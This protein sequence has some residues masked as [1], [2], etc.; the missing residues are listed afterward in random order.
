[1]AL[2][3]AGTTG[4]ATVDFSTGSSDCYACHAAGTFGF[5]QNS[6]PAP[7]WS[8]SYDDETISVP[9]ETAPGYYMISV[10]TGASIDNRCGQ[11]LSAP[12]KHLL[13]SV[14]APDSP[15]DGPGPEPPCC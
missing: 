10:R 7:G 15:P 11:G 3:K 13:V 2:I 9:P 1:M 4:K 8:A 6:T 12:C 14:V 5:N